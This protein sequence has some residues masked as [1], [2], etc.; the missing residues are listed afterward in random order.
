MSR[1]KSKDTKIE[2][3]VR[4]YLFAKGYRFRKN[5]ERYPGKPDVVLPKYRTFIFVNGCFWHMHSGCKYGRL[6]KSNTDYWKA[7]LE[8]NVKNDKKHIKDLQEMGWKV[9]VLWECELNKDFEGVM[10]R[11]IQVISNDNKNDV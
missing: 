9:I 2:V 5:D 11:T 10:E 6:P 1:I 7:K 3:R 8:K 4:K